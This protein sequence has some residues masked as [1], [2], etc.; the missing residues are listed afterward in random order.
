MKKLLV[1]FGL[2]LCQ[3]YLKSQNNLP[4]YLVELK[5]KENNTYSINNPEEFLSQKAIERRKKQNILISISDLPLSKAYLEVLTQKGVKIV[6]KSKWLNSIVIEV[7]NTNSL[8]EIENLSFVKKVSSLGNNVSTKLPSKFIE[9]EKQYF[10]STKIDYN[11]GTSFNQSNLIGVDCMHKNG[12]TGKGLVIAVIDAGFYKVDSLPAFKYIRD[13]GQILGTHD[14]VKGNDSVYEDHTHGMAVLSTIAGN[15]DGQIIGTAPDAKFWLLR[16]EDAA[17]EYIQEEFFWTIAAEFAD[18]VGVDIIN[19]SLGYSVFDD[20]ST[21]HTYADMDGNTTMITKAADLAASK[22]IFV[23]CSAGN[24]GGA[25]WFKITAPSDADS[26]LTIGAVDSV[27]KIT[28]FSGR[29]PTFDNRIKPDVCAKGAKVAYAHQNGTIAFGGGT[30]FSSPITAG[31]VA[32]LWQANPNV[33]SFK[34]MDI[35][36]KSAHRYV[37]PDTVYGFGIPNFCYAHDML[38]QYV[39]INDVEIIDISQT[40]FY[41]NF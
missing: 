9:E 27:G 4:K 5:D 36:K 12:Y 17:T 11:Y 30:S 32:C 2:L 35:V 41:N 10:R 3:F 18:S 38:N 14:F 34:L 33:T 21:N 37:N 16:S 7:N 40:P 26:V 1:L 19:S 39:N 13:N 8:A 24:S 23:C 22:G 15:I 6:G 28:S 29:G 20:T 31:A 25:P